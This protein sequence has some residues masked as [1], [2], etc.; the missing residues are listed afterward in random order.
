VRSIVHF[1][2]L[3]VTLV[4]A[5]AGSAPAQEPAEVPLLGSLDCQVTY[6]EVVVQRYRKIRCLFLPLQSQVPAFEELTGTLTP[7]GPPPTG[8]R[9][10]WGVYSLKPVTSLRGTY[11]QRSGTRMLIGASK[12]EFRPMA[13]VPGEEV[14]RNLAFDATGLVLTLR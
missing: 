4:A 12:T 6:P 8:T 1:F 11:A 13:D 14:G 2:A 3:L 7:I 9:A 10:V 5:G